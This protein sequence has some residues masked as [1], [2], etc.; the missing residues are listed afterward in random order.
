[1]KA[2]AESLAV[3]RHLSPDRI[4]GEDCIVLDARGKFPKRVIIIEAGRKCEY[5]L[6]RTRNG[7][8]LLN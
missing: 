8:F 5:R 3:K 4:E 1:M 7:G 6:I 2:R